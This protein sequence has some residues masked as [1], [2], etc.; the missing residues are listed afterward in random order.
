MHNPWTNLIT[1]LHSSEHQTVLAITGGGSQ[2]IG[3]LL[4]VP[5]GS[6]T[7]LEAIV[8]YASTAL[9]DWLGS[10]AEQSCSAPTARAM[11]M[12]SWMRAR[13]LS[14]ETD[15]HQL[16][17]VGATASLVSDRPKRGDHRVHIAVQTATSTA[18]YSLVLAKEERDRIAEETL[19]AQMILLGLATTCEVDTTDARSIFEEQLKP[20]EQIIFSQQQAEASWT[21]LLLGK[22][23]FVSY[24][25]SSQPQAQES[26]GIF[27]GSFNPLHTGHQHIA[28]IAAKRL[29]CPVAYELSITNVEKPPLDF[30]EIEERVRGLRGE[31]ASESLDSETL[32]LT[33]APTFRA[34]AALFPGCTFVVGADTIARIADPKYYCGEAG[35][36]DAA[37]ELIAEQGCRFL[38]FGREIEGEFHMLSDIKLPSALLELCDE[39]TAE[40]FR[41]DVS[42][43]EIRRAAR[44]SE[45]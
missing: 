31:T 23:Q 42:S 29:A 35:S 7:L 18:T 11:A 27:P 37:I 30:V 15:P 12:A 32:L 5:G 44:L 4:E 9:A 16:V 41:E 20:N 21:A 14:P 40:E 3:R 8:P 38:V 28:S 17:G 19:A 25:D 43:S 45:S 2:A 13:T 24:P 36:F 33:D 26:R 10:A 1:D 39:V 34:K 22:R 6:R